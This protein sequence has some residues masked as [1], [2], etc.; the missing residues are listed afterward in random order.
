MPPHETVRPT[1][2]AHTLPDASTGSVSFH[3]SLL[4]MLI[5]D[6]ERRYVDANPA[7]CL[8]LRLPRFSVLKLRVDDLTPE[9]NRSLVQRLWTR[10]IEQ[11]TQ[12]G[13]Y[14]LAM[15]D[16]QRVQVAYSATANYLPGRHISI[17]DLQQPTDRLPAELSSVTTAE[18][19]LTG[20]EREVLS[21]VAMGE[22]SQGIAKMLYLS[23]ATVET[24]VRNCQR[25]LGARNRPHAILL[26][27]KHGEIS[28]F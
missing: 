20:R 26:A 11:G 17:L 10:F 12:A 2:A 14:E 21:L 4:P 23:T 8:L 25:K 5:A 19:R 24:H 22:T 15:P 6:D 13:L 28:I 7:A 9:K 27:L 1:R 3:Q 18:R 16:G